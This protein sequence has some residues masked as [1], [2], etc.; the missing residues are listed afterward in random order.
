MKVI[1]DASH[2]PPFMTPEGAERRILSYGG[3]MMLVQFTFPPGVTAPIH[4]HHHEQI[5]YVVS[6][7]IDLLTEGQETRRLTAGCSYYVAP[8]IRHGIVTY[9]PTVLLDSFTPI[10]EDFLG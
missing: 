5:G 3:S 6:C 8:D 7:E 1:A 10:R 9:A 2:E 4:S